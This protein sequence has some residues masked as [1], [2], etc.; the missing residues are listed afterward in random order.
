[1][2]A[3]RWGAG[4][5]AVGRFVAEIEAAAAGKGPLRPGYVLA[6]DETFL[7]DRCRGAVLKAFVP[8]IYGTFASP[9]STSLA[10]PSSKCL[11][12]RR[13]LR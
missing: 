11:T 9:I 1:M 7:L 3:G 6:G 10:L 2:T 5:A 12:A 8:P 13:R 4:F